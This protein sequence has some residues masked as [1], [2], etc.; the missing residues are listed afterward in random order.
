MNGKSFLFGYSIVKGDSQRAKDIINLC[1]EKGIPF[2][3]VTLEEDERFSLYVPLF[4]ER[5]LISLAKAEKI[6]LTVISRRGV[7]SLFVRHRLRIGMLV[8]LIVSLICFFISSGFIW[9]IQIDGAIR[10]DEKKL[11]ATFKECGLCVG[12]RLSDIDADVLENQ[13]LILSDDISWVS[14]N[15]SGNVANVEI[16]E[17]DYAPPDEYGDALYSN[18]VASQSGVIVSF[19]DVK[20]KTVTDI[21]EAVCEGQLLIS[22]ILGG[23]GLPTRLTNAHGRV[24]A[25]VEEQI[26]IK[27]PQKYIKKV[28]KNEIKSEK[29]LFFF[30]NEIKFFSNSRNLPSFYDTINIIENFYTINHKK[31]PFGIKTVK[32]VEYEEVEQTRSREEMLSLAYSELYRR[33]NVY[34]ADA[35]I[36]SRSVS[37]IDGDSH[38]TL[39]CSLSCIK[40]IA[41]VSEI[42]VS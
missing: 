20:G 35:E 21:G 41:C 12:A 18:V 17:T 8:G 42:I 9:D 6:E 40:N 31:L 10:S 32:Y 23:D 11:L 16:R 39:I 29:S 22:G 4:Y 14:V 38:L 37:V 5:K 13:I 27:I 33:I 28:T 3:S 25:E 34:Y 1:N 19:E 24:F 2:S 15:L 26:E 36:L 30:E 7:A